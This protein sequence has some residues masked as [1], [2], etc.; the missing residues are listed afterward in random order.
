MLQSPSLNTNGMAHDYLFNLQK[1][2][3]VVSSHSWINIGKICVK[4]SFP[5]IA[6]HLL[7]LVPISVKLS[8]SSC[9]ALPA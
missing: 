3:Q 8:R 4:D 2:F 6:S 7:H 1:Y 9:Q 5:V